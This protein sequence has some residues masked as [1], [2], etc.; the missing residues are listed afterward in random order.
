MKI[1]TIIPARGRKP[2]VVKAVQGRPQIRTIIPARGRK[3]HHSTKSN[4]QRQRDKNHNPRKGTETTLQNLLL[5]T[6]SSI[7]T[8]I[9]AR[10]RKLMFDM[11]YSV[12]RIVIRTIIPA[13]GRK[14]FFDFFYFVLVNFMIRTIIPARGRKLP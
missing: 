9:P 10:G 1:R 2:C 4:F 7:R 11:L 8:I 3:P 6:Y 13:R 14:R 12:P 5:P